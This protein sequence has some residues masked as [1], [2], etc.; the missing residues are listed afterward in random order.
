MSVELGHFAAVLA[1]ALACGMAVLGLGARFRLLATGARALPFLVT[2]QFVLVALAFGLLMHAFAT[3]D[4]SVRYVSEHSNTQLPFMYKLAALWGGHEGSFLLW[5][6]IMCTWMLAVAVRSAHLPTVFRW[7]VL[8]VM[9]L[10]NVGFLAFLLFTSNPFRRL[11][12][13]TPAEGVDLN[14]LLQDFGLTVHPPV[15]YTGYVGFSV[16]FAFAIAAL[17]SGRLDAAW[18]RWSRPWTNTAWAF[19][20]IGIALGSWWAYYELGWG[21][22]WFWDPVENASFMP[23]LIGTALVHSLAATEK[24]G[25]FK[26]W[27]LLL[28]IAAFSLSLLGAFIVRSGVLT[29]VHA[30][31]VDPERGMF[32]L[33][34]LA[35]VVG[36][37]LTLYG[38]RAWQLRSR[39][40]FDWLSRDAFLL[41]NNILLAVA[42]GVVLTGTLWPLGYEA[43]TGDKLSVGK[44]YFNQLFV[45]LM[46][47]LCALLV[48]APVVN[49]K[50]TAPSR[51][52]ALLRWPLVATGVLGLGAVIAL[53]GAF[54]LPRLAAMVAVVLAIAIVAS[55]AADLVRKLRSGHRPGVA[56][57]GMCIA[58]VGFAMSVAGVALTVELSSEKDLAMHPGDTVEREGRQ[59]RF[60]SVEDGRGPNYVAQVGQFAITENGREFMLRPEKR[61]Y[62]AGGNMMTEAAI[63]PGFLRDVYISLGEPLEAGAWA[64]RVHIKPFV[65]WIWFGAIIMAAGGG[66]AILDRRYRLRVAARAGVAAAGGAP[67]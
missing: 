5:V 45:P 36:G 59:I 40:S 62:V 35:V 56:W 67:A 51:I 3:D 28:A 53:W 54:D 37:S 8:G 16:A 44:P 12:P 10:M 42:L 41:Q 39:A 1:F 48:L 43:I 25:V 26:S 57:L 38:A 14:P 50:R 4:F 7:N 58:H 23:W 29:S 2:G 46:L 27:T 34:F 61:R 55:H 6:L 33:I 49:W 15:L 52:V 66:L 19:L 17:L 13:F 18:A 9:A 63:D 20:T 24:R 11:V 64:V 47:L 21:G 31:A 65:R 30:F 32:I 60:V 22:W